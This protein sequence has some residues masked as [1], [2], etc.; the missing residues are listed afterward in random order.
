MPMNVLLA[1]LLDEADLAVGLQDGPA[2]VV[3]GRDAVEPGLL[4]QVVRGKPLPVPRTRGAATL[5]ATAWAKPRDPLARKSYSV[6][7]PQCIRVL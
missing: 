5:T 2:D 1:G 7:L 6:A 3:H 4:G